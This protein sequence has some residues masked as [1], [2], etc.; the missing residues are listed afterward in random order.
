MLE[1]YLF[2]DESSLLNVYSLQGPTLW[3]ADWLVFVECDI[4]TVT[5]WLM[6]AS[7]IMI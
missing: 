4:A 6:L 3:L 7:V 2:Y 5:G 1:F